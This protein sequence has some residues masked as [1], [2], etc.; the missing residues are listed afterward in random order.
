MPD[1]VLFTSPSI[2]SSSPPSYQTDLLTEHGRR[3]RIWAAE[4]SPRGADDVIEVALR[5]VLR[6]ARVVELEPWHKNE[7]FILSFAY[8][9]KFR[10]SSE[11]SKG[12]K[13]LRGQ[14]RRK[15]TPKLHLFAGPANYAHRRQG[16]SVKAL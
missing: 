4:I 10:T 14:K 11:E 12:S 5:Q 1:L 7:V 6:V 9:K 2:T 3:L 8:H 16:H 13:K 15:Q